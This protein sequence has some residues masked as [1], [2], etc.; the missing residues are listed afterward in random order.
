[1]KYSKDEVMMFVTEEDVKF[2]RLAFCDTKGMVKNV[3]ILPS[4]LS[5]AFAEGIPFEAVILSDSYGVNE[6]LYLHPDPATL[7]LLP[8]RPDHGRVVRMFCEVQHKDGTVSP[9]DYRTKLARLTEHM[10]DVCTQTQ[11]DFYLF[12]LDENNVAS[13]N[14][15]DAAGYMDIAPI[16]KCENIRRSI[17]LTLESM[18]MLP[19]TSCHSF[20]PGQNRISYRSSDLLSSADDMIT[21]YTVVQSMAASNGL[22]ASFA[23]KPLKNLKESHTVISYEETKQVSFASDANPYLAHLLIAL[24]MESKASLPSIV[25]SVETQSILKKILPC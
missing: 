15:Y 17:C 14:V 7:A 9:Y 6:K 1:M 5:L 4:E 21:F 16:D 23:V 22:S 3:S 18:G 11:I 13:K 2:I 12:T 24:S 8:W 25:E 19:T 20:G 10:Q